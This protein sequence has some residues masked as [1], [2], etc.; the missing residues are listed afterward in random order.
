MQLFGEI[1]DYRRLFDLLLDLFDEWLAHF[2]YKVVG[3]QLHLKICHNFVDRP[4]YHV[5]VKL[6]EGRL[7][8]HSLSLFPEEK[9][10]PETNRV[11]VHILKEIAVFGA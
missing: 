4:L 3:G 7:V 9:I 2:V 10:L 6:K 1:N 11:L 8:A 5:Q